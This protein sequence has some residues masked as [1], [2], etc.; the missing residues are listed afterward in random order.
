MKLVFLDPFSHRWSLAS[1][2]EHVSAQE[3][4]KRAAELYVPVP[5]V[6]SPEFAEELQEIA[7]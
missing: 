2:V 5:S 3:S 1:R 7:A 4:S 6:E